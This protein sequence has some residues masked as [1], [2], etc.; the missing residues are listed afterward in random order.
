[1]M[2]NVQEYANDAS[3]VEERTFSVGCRIRQWL[4]NW[5]NKVNVS[6]RG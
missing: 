4:S 3:S 5:R 6:V 1:M 2:S